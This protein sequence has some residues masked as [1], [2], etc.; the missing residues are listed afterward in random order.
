MKT[1]VG[2]GGDRNRQAEKRDLRR[3][4]LGIRDE[5]E[6]EER[7]KASLLMTERILGHQWFYRSAFFLCYV[8]YGSEIA[9]GELLKE[10]WKAGKKV[11]VPKVLSAY[12][13]IPQMSFFRIAGPEDLIKGYKGIP[14]PERA[15]EEYLYSEGTA[16]HTLMLM[17]GVAF[18]RCRN[19]IGYGKGFYDRYLADKPLLQFRTIAVGYRCQMVDEIPAKA[20][21]IRPYQVIC[22]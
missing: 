13:G 19:R 22:V 6:Q 1:D 3:K 14:E 11:Y 2:S 9:T 18:D 8:S 21:D 12:T 7:D 10:A 20:G 15:E 5:M 17:P 4:V 16:E